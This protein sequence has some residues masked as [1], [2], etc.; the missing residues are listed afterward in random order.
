MGEDRPGRSRRRRP[1]R[2]WG[3][4]SQLPQPQPEARTDTSHPRRRMSQVVNFA[5]QDWASLNRARDNLN[6]GDD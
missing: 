5:P 6:A 3:R 4:D 1:R 2:R